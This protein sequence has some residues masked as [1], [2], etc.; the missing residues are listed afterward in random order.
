[1]TSQSREKIWAALLHPKFD[2]DNSI[3]KKFIKRLKEIKGC[4]RVSS[5]THFALTTW[6]GCS[7]PK[8]DPYTIKAAA[9][10]KEKRQVVVYKKK[11]LMTP[12]TSPTTQLV[13][14]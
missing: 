13:N 7:D 3:N 4:G 10:K 9:R 12:P 8:T 2:E 5:I 6:Q 1:M 14:Q 11:R